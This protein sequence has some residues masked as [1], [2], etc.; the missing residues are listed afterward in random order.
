MGAIE[1][2]R[3]FSYLKADPDYRKKLLLLLI[4]SLFPVLN[5]ALLGYGVIIYRNII[6]GRKDEDLQPDWGNAGDF[7]LKGIISTCIAVGYG[8]VSCLLC[9]LVGL[10]FGVSAV[11]SM[12]TGGDAHFPIFYLIIVTIISYAATLG[13]WAGYTLYAESLE[14]GRAF[15]FAE[16]AIRV[17][18]LGV[19][20]FIVSAIWLAVAASI[21]WLTRLMPWFGMQALLVLLTYL[22]LVMVYVMA[23]LAVKDVNPVLSDVVNTGYMEYAEKTYKASGESEDKYGNMKLGGHK[24]SHY[25]DHQPE[26]TL[27]WSTDSDMPE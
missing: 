4:V 26:T 12:I 3:A 25:A 2:R 5:C 1:W 21:S 18:T 22:S 15:R 23:R 17:Y 16:V 27:T 19:P 6:D 10:V 13:F 7:I 20:M 11:G 9:L 24:A 8:L 14:L